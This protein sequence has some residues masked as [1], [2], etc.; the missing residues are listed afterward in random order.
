[1]GGVVTELRCYPVKG[2]RGHARPA[3]RVQPL[4]LDGDRRWM[5][6]TPDGAF[7]SQRQLP[8]MA[9]IDAR[10]AADGLLLAADGEQFA[11]PEP[12][13]DAE[14][15]EVQVWG[16][17]VPALAAGPAADR[18]LG[19][20]LGLRCRL[21]FLRD[22]RGRRVAAPFDAGTDHVSFADGFPLLLTAAG[23][24][25]ALNAAL[26][27]DGAAPV[28]MDRF[29]A[30]VVVD[31]TPAWAEH[32]W[33]RVRIGGTWFRAPK[34]CERCV[35]VTRDQRDGETPAPGQPLRTLGRL[36]RGATGIL[37]G[38]NLIPDGDGEIRVGDPV[39]G[40]G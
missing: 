21:V 38:L 39:E 28:P 1:M 12:D 23:S 29:R 14:A 30:N 20:R 16:S 13:A 24:L 35:V 31:G 9:R 7:L 17:A 8:G 27:A 32:G 18:W 22:E 34:P 2:L 36:S 10:P 6:V 37:F 5:V 19:E 3:A 15:I 11:V 4:G 40:V 25:D 26:R 33:R